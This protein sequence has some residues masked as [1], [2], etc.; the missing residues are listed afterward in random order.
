MKEEVL[1][2][3]ER[4]MSAAVHEKQ[5]EKRNGSKRMEGRWGK[6]RIEWGRK[7]IRFLTMQIALLR[8]RISFPNRRNRR[9]ELAGK[10]RVNWIEV[11]EEEKRKIKKWK[12]L[13]GRDLRRKK[14]QKEICY[15]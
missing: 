12:K 11:G 15:D 3:D 13:G 1:G 10:E 9:E 6:K 8:F 14:N 5:K 4:L 7:Y 2:Y